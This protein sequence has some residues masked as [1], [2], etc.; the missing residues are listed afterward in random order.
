VGE[1]IHAELV[2]PQKCDNNN[3]EEV[4]RVEEEVE[5]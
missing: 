5:A 1:S 2:K 4:M 3:V